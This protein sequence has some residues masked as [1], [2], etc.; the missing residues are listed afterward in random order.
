ML[1]KINGIV[2]SLRISGKT[3]VLAVL[4]I[5]LIVVAGNITVKKA[6]KS[7]K[8]IP[9]WSWSL[10]DKV[11]VI[12]AGHGGVDPGAVGYNN[13]LEKDITLEIAKRLKS[14]FDQAGSNVIMIR[15]EDRDFGQ[16]D[17]LMTRKREDLAYRLKTALDSK[18]DVY[19][20]IHANSF[21]DRSQHGAQVFYHQGSEQGKQL[22]EYVQKYLNEIA[23]RKREAKPNQ[24]YFILKNCQ[25][26]VLTIEVGF[27]SNPEEEVKLN[28]PEYQ[29]RLAM[30]IFEGVANYMAKED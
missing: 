28:K 14:L 3:L 22:G 6:M 25:G 7:S 20:C 21:P 12:D 15:E 9:G 19:L 30:A 29:Q 26:S 24:S 23:P 8:D 4:I 18:A 10:G 2:K 5:G 16:S 13:T 17:S 27:L 11:I 1:H